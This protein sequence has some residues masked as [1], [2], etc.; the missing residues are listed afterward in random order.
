MT[1]VR[2]AYVHLHSMLSTIEIAIMI[3]LLE[4]IDLKYKFIYLLLSC[5]TLSI[6]KIYVR[7]KIAKSHIA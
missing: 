3:L 5:R 1:N 7:L 2:E 6:M 4:S